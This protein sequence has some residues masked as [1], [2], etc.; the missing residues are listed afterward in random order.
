MILLIRYSVYTNNA[1]S[2]CYIL[3]PHPEF[4]LLFL[5]PLLVTPERC[6]VRTQG[7]LGFYQF[8][9]EKTVRACGYSSFPVYR[10]ASQFPLVRRSPGL[11]SVIPLRSTPLARRRFR[12]TFFFFSPSFLSRCRYTCLFPSSSL[13][14]EIALLSLSLSLPSLISSRGTGTRG[15]KDAADRRC[16]VRTWGKCVWKLGHGLSP[17][18]PTRFCVSRFAAG[19]WEIAHLPSFR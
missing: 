10:R 19:P 5:Y 13:S 11:V 6:L 7:A 15:E 12:P 18:A 9:S 3:M 16:N 4:A 14:T 1:D 17:P 8:L 2:R